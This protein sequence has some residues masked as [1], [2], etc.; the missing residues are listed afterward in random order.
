MKPKTFVL[1]HLGTGS[2]YDT[3]DLGL[4]GTVGDTAFAEE[5]L[6]DDLSHLGGKLLLTLE[7]LSHEVVLTPGNGGS[8]FSS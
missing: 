7:D 2:D 5:A 4:G 8:I 3:V 1:Y 6:A